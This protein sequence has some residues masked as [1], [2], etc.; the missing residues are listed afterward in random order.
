MKIVFIKNFHRTIYVYFL[1]ALVYTR[2]ICEFS[3]GSVRLNL[4]KYLKVDIKLRI[5]EKGGRMSG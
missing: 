5:E 1:Y 2:I 4:K 3:T